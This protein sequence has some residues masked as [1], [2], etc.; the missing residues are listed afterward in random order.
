MVVSLILPHCPGCVFVVTA[1]AIAEFGSG[2]IAVDAEW[3]KTGGASRGI[4]RVVIFGIS[5][6]VN[7]ALLYR[8]YLVTPTV[9]L[10]T[11]TDST[12]NSP[13]FKMNVPICMITS[14][15]GSIMMLCV[16]GITWWRM[17]KQYQ[18]VAKKRFLQNKTVLQ[19]LC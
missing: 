7:I 9:H 16:N 5:R 6:L 8:I 19:K 10:F 1:F 3:R 13:I 11:L 2:A 12:N 17:W 14:V 18:K 4:K 15:G